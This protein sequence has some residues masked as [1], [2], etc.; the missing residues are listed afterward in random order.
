[1]RKTRMKLALALSLAA[2]AVAIP[3]TLIS[4]ASASDAHSLT[5]VAAAATARFHDLAAAQDAGW[6]VLVKDT[7]GLTCIEDPPAGGGMGVHWANGSLLFDANLDPATPEALVY[8]PN[9][10]G[11]PKL[12]ALEYIVLAPAWTAA[13]HAANDPP[14]LFGRSFD[15]T[16][17]G[18]RFGLP[19]FWSLHVWIWQPNAAGMFKPWNPGVH[20]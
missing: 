18:N 4:L 12:A 9:A 3:L 5:T 16:P 2:A 19:A 6:D 1:M 11:S 7:A 20:C 14:T 13:G 17:D 15:L 8:A 10:A